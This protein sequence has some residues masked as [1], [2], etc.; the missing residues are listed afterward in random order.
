MDT[1]SIESEKRTRFFTEIG[2]SIAGGISRALSKLSAGEIAVHFIGVQTHKKISAAINVDEKCFGSYVTISNVD[3]DLKGTVF[4]FFPLSSIS[5]LIEIILKQQFDTDNDIPAELKLSTFKEI[6]RILLMRYVNELANALG[7]QL[8]TS[9]PVFTSFKSMKFM[10]Q[11]EWVDM[12]S[13]SLITVMQLDISS[14]S[15]DSSS[16]KV[17]GHFVVIF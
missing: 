14:Q 1:V 15:S 9:V 5:Y 8:N 17:R 13:T 16:K 12:K 10:K 11:P 7:I 2:P 3:K 6:N 4:L